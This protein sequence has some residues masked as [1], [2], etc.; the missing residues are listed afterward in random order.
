MSDAISGIS[1]S[2]LSD[3]A[4]QSNINTKVSADKTLQQAARSFESLYIQMLLKSMRGVNNTLKSEFS[5]H[6]KNDTY[7]DLLD[8][9]LSIALSA[10]QSLGIADL[11]IKQLS[12]SS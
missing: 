10:T 5:A 8:Q 1:L 6:Q 3:I 12:G 7:Q 11:M 4:L 2:S 9:Q